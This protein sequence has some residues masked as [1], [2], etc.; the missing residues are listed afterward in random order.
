MNRRGFVGLLGLFAGCSARLPLDGSER[1]S[2]RTPEP[3]SNVN[4]VDATTPAPSGP[5]PGPTSEPESDPEAVPEPEREPEPPEPVEEVILEEEPA[6]ERDLTDREVRGLETLRNADRKIT[7]VVRAFTDGYG[8]ELTDVTATSVGFL[9]S[10]YDVRLALAA[11]QKDYV[12]AGQRAAN[13]EQETSAA[14]LVACWQFL[15]HATGTQVAVVEAYEHL[16]SALADF[17]RD[18]Y[19]GGVG[20]ADE[21]RTLLTAAD[22][23]LADIRAVST[24]DDIAAVSAISAEEYEAKVAQFEAD[25][26]AY[27]DLDGAIREFAEGIKWLRRAKAYDTGAD[28]NVQKARDAAKDARDALRSARRS[29]DGVRSRAGDDTSLTPVLLAFRELASAKTGEATEILD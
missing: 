11:A 25:V 26:G 19:E 8:T 27:H 9:R 3:V 29:V 4:V 12:K 15:R 24:V 22:R 17:E 2:V 6:P 1:G 23:G 5:V 14:Q 13:A 7:A 10:E 16:A 18:F 21:I 20:A 28:R